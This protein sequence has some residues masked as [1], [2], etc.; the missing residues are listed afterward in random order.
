LTAG[1]A[2]VGLGALS[3]SAAAVVALPL[4]YGWILAEGLL[5]RRRTR[6]VLHLIGD[7]DDRHP[8][9]RNDIARVT[10]GLGENTELAAIIHR[11]GNAP[12][13]DALTGAAARAFLARMLPRI[14]RWG[15]SAQAVRVALGLIEGTGSPAAFLR[16]R[17][18]EGISVRLPEVG[19]SGLDL[20]QLLQLTR[21]TR[22]GRGDADGSDAH[23][24]L[25][26]LALEIALGE[27][28]ERRALD[29]ELRALTDRWREAEEI[30]SIADTLPDDPLRR[31]LRDRT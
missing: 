22:R 18:G 24:F 3:G 29:G 25:V 17:G 10:L 13:A 15:G 4:A 28:S 16:A 21:A 5:H 11:R 31:W 12:R 19:S 6:E 27:E 9:R 20:R 1:A 8:V 30:A 2:A 26:S 23:P 7:A 14:N